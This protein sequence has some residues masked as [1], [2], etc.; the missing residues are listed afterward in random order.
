MTTKPNPTITNA[1]RAILVVTIL[2]VLPFAGYYYSNSEY[3]TGSSIFVEEPIFQQVHVSMVSDGNRKIDFATE[4]LFD[5]IIP[6][7][8]KTSWE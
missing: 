2:L 5:E 3:S 7:E 8:F 4:S 1:R 6:V